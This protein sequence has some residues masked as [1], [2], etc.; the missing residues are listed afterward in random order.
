LIDRVFPG[1]E[2]IVR[3]R[4][5]SHPTRRSGRLAAC[6]GSRRGAAKRPGD[7]TKKQAVLDEPRVSV[8]RCEC[9]SGLSWER[10]KNPAIDSSTLSETTEAWC[11]ILENCGEP[12]LLEYG[13]RSSTGTIVRLPTLRKQKIV[14]SHVR[15]S[16]TL[17]DGAAR[18]AQHE[19][20][21]AKGWLEMQAA[22]IDLVV[23]SPSPTFPTMPWNFTNTWKHP[24]RPNARRSYPVCLLQSEGRL[25]D[26][27]GKKFKN[28]PAAVSV[29]SE[30]LKAW[31]TRRLFLALPGAEAQVKAGAAV[32]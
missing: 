17:R 5:D 7:G 27:L 21:A 23:S 8:S 6:S 1:A 22:D 4:L 18:G 26:L 29:F 16:L 30:T 10:F 11:A 13:H 3:Q 2:P 28:P 15:E 14:Y 12:V 24:D 25:A 31:Q 19:R 9:F 32:H 20:S